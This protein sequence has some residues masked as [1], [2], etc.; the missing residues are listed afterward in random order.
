MAYI[1][2][3]DFMKFLLLLALILFPS[4]AG[5]AGSAIAAK[6]QFALNWKAE[7]EFGGF[8]AAKLSGSLKK[9]NLDVDITEGGAGTPVVQM[10][11][12]GKVPFGIA[13]A[14]EVVISQAR[15]TDVVALFAVYQ[16]NPQG[17]MVHPERGFK[18]IA[19]VLDSPGT[20]AIQNGSPHALFLQSQF[21]SYKVRL[22]PY[23]GGV[24]TFLT[25]PNYSQQ[26]FVTSEP[27][28][29]RKKGRPAQSFL[30]ADAGF[31]P[32]GTVVIARR[33]Y[34]EKNQKQTRDLID[35]IREGWIEYLRAP[36]KANAL[37]VKL[38][39]AMDADTMKEAAEVQKPYIVSSDGSPKEL[40]KMTAERWIT[41]IN[42]LFDLKL[43]KK[44]PQAEKLLQNF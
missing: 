8:Y 2:K 11:A 7:P 44:K 13:A 12:N 21:P 36:E 15:G 34:I 28:I 22:V 5:S 31:K 3:E 26:C 23:A 4:I 16:I 39:P 43:I 19:D 24:A 29:A 40:G 1:G 42:Q 6:L 27:L 9:R 30:I 17:I 41:L 18:S 35:A 32:Y 37:M 25:D 33:Q 38:N 20:L 14:D 10:V